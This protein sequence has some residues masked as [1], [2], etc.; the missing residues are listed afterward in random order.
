MVAVAVFQLGGV[1][2]VVV[3]VVV[4]VVVHVVVVVAVVGVV[5]GV[6]VVVV[7]VVV[8]VV[9]KEDPRDCPIYSVLDWNKP[10]EAGGAYL[11]SL[12]PVNL[13]YV[14]ML[15]SNCDFSNGQLQQ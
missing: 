8:V 4:H 9:A 7:V 13:R 14:I 1:V 15:R 3:V 5:G 12:V 2:A 6:G 10:D 11:T